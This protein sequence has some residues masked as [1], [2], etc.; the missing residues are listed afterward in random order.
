VVVNRDGAKAHQRIIREQMAE[1]PDPDDHLK[2]EASAS[3][4]NASVREITRAEAQPTIMQYEWLGNMGSA[5]YFIGLFFK[6]PVTSA[7][8][9]GGVACFGITGGSKVNQSICGA[10]HAKQVITLVRGACVH[11][12]HPHAASYLVNRACDLMVGRGYNIFI[13]YS[14]VKAGEIGTVY[15]ASGWTYVGLTGTPTIIV[16]NDREIDSRIIG[17]MTRDRS[18]RG[19]TLEEINAWADRMRAEGR[20]VKGHGL[21]QYVETM[22]RR[23]AKARLI[24]DGAVFKRGTPKHRYIHFAGDKRTVR[25]LRKALQL[26]EKPYPKRGSV[27][28]DTIGSTDGSLVRS[29]DPAPTTQGIDYGQRKQ[30]VEVLWTND[31]ALSDRDGCWP[32]VEPDAI[33]TE[34]TQPFQLF[35][36]DC[37][38]VLQSLPEKSIDLVLTDLP[39]GVTAC[40]W[41]SVLP[42]DKL[43]YEYRRVARDTT[44]FVFIATQPFT[45]Q[46][47]SS[48]ME[49]FRYELVWEKPRGTNP[50]NAKKMPLKSHENIVVFYKKTPTYNPQMEKGVPYSAFVTKSGATIGEAYGSSKSIHAANFGTRYPKSVLKFKQERGL[51]PTQKPVPLMEYLIRTYSNEG[52][53]VLDNC[54]GVGTTGLAAMNTKRQFIGIEF[55]PKF[56]AMA[57]ERLG[58][59]AGINCGSPQSPVEGLALIQRRVVDPAFLTRIA[60]DSFRRLGRY[61]FVCSH[62]IS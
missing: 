42:L 1:K 37:L 44:A 26:Q 62:E 28:G 29:Q 52:D 19:K 16:R 57:E 36:G 33:L 12:A 27:E 15:Q 41:D 9:L 34:I 25:E 50:L 56:F 14:D 20:I 48:C 45:T 24:A 38:T 4:S 32:V 55:D 35:R 58:S 46:L 49:W 60:Q 61:A 39:C 51:H 18:G 43:W 31:G 11:W 54:M 47:I 13:A 59:L 2:R 22:T 7:E 5:K 30:S 17:C 53:T 21:D 10:Q 6:H 40:K 23:E 8:Y 3:L